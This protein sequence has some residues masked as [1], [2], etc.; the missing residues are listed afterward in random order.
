MHREE[1]QRLDIEAVRG[2]LSSSYFGQNDLLLYL[3]TV[4]STNTY[5]LQLAR[6]GAAEGVVVVTDSQTAGK[7]RLGRRWI[8]VTGCNVISS[9]VV[10]P[11]FPPFFLIMAASLAVVKAIQETA[12]VEA[13]IKWPNDVLIRDRKVAGILIETSHDRAGHLV[14][15]IGIGINVKAC[16][17]GVEEHV[18]SGDDGWAALE[19]K[20]TALETE[21]GF[22]VSRE[23]V[24]TNLLRHLEE[25]YLQ[26]QEEAREP[27]ASAY[28]SASRLIREQWRNHL[29]TLGRTIEVRQGDTLLSGVAED[30]DDNGELLLRNRSGERVLIT[31][32]DVGYP[33]V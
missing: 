22:A 4:P 14:A 2:Q 13:T 5:A 8:D 19:A 32:G 12:H 20:A 7:G 3:P 28:G 23:S 1:L 21:A 26:L 33:T 31:W 18:Q 15:I 27:N 25:Y 30:V 17:P 10:R 9:T 6:E 29:S 24:L 11:Q 16:L